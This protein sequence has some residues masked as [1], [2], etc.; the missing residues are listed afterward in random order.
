MDMYSMAKQDFSHDLRAYKNLSQKAG[1][2]ST[3]NT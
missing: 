1:F 2:L 3:W